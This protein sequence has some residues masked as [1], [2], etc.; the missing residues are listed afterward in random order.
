MTSLLSCS[1]TLNLLSCDSISCSGNSYSSVRIFGNRKQRLPVSFLGDFGW[2]FVSFCF[3]RPH[4]SYAMSH[5]ASKVG[6]SH[7]GL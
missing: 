2:P 6:T 5:F 1:F 3:H 7:G 4:I